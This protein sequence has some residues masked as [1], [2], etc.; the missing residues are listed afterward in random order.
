MKNATDI[1]KNKAALIVIAVIA[2]IIVNIAVDI[3]FYYDYRDKMNITAAML[4]AEDPAAA[5]ADILK[6]NLGDYRKGSEFLRENGYDL[7]GE[8]RFHRQLTDR[9]IAAAG[10]SAALLI[11][12]AALLR[13]AEC[14][15]ERR[16]QNLLGEIEQAVTDFREK[17]ILSVSLSDKS[18]EA[19]RISWQLDRLFE[20]IDRVQ[21]QAA[22]EKEEI[23]SIVTDISHQLKTPVSVIDINLS[24]LADKNLSEAERSEFITRLV[25]ALGELETLMDSLLKIS[26]LETGIIKLHTE[27]TCIGDT[28]RKAVSCIYSKAQQKNIDIV[29]DADEAVS[30]K[31]YIYDGKWICEAMIN[32]LDNAVKYSPDGSSVH[33]NLAERTEFLRIEITDEGIGINKDEYHKVFRRFYRGSSDTVKMQSGSGIGLY[34]VRRITD[35]HGGMVSVKQG[36]ASGKYPGASFVMQLPLKQR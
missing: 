2:V 1:F 31:Q 18:D 8:S 5:A 34:L 36:R 14:S 6:G 20:Y 26:K 19:Q 3:C 13:A 22:E 25:D 23:Q 30:E 17:G 29:F 10:I 27:K 15:A 28:V 24:L 32:I 9:C 21:A 33:I 7:S 35:M 11:I 4:S 16:N 12:F